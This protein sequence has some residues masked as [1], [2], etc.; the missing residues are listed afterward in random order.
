MPRRHSWLQDY[1]YELDHGPERVVRDQ[2]RDP[3]RDDSRPSSPVNITININLGDLIDKMMSGQVSTKEALEETETRI[4][5]RK[6][7]TEDK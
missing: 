7:L 2:P 5:R 6:I 1:H 3:G 4:E